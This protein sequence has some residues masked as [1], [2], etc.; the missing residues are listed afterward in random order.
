MHI[1]V[2]F[3]FFLS[4]FYAGSKLL[5]TSTSTG[6]WGWWDPRSGW[7]SLWCS[8]WQRPCKY[9]QLWKKPSVKCTWLGQY[10]VLPAHVWRWSET[11]QRFSF[12]DTACLTG[13]GVCYYY[14]FQKSS[15]ISLFKS[16]AFFFLKVQVRKWAEILKIKISKGNNNAKT[17]KWISK[18]RF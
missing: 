14:D 12:F 16:C 7:H 10:S 8:W 11:V 13:V 17:K 9:K 15:G 5:D 3:F 1:C 6:A 2:M 18:L 4:A